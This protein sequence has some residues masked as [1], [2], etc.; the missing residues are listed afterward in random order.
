MFEGHSKNI[1]K[2]VQGLLSPLNDSQK[3]C[4]LNAGVFEQ[5]VFLGN[6]D[7]RYRQAESV[8]KNN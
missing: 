5:N 8:I 3:D 1:K 4:P 6:I 7:M 2:Y